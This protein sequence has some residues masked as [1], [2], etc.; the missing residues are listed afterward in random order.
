M[1]LT[2][3][4]SIAQYPTCINSER[5]RSLNSLQISRKPLQ[6]YASDG[7]IRYVVFMPREGMFD[8]VAS[9]SFVAIVDIALFV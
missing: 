5:Q 4:I 8:F 3:M 1:Q 9:A 2:K 6:A 7:G